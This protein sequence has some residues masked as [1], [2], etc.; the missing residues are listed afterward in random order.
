MGT[1]FMTS[2]KDVFPKLL[3]MPTGGVDTTKESIASWY[4]AVVVADGMGSKLISKKLME[5]KDYSKIEND[6][7]QVLNTIKAIRQ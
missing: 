6:T 3:F 5:A 2:I 4:K 7:V 1:E